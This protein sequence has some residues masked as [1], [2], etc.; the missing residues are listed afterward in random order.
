MY[1]LEV[2]YQ[3]MNQTSTLSEIPR[4][5]VFMSDCLLEVIKEKLSPLIYMHFQSVS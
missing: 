1:T 5:D 2:L 4:E 3:N